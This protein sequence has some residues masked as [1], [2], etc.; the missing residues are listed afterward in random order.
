MTLNKLLNINIMGEQNKYGERYDISDHEAI[1]VE[2]IRLYTP[3][4]LIKIYQFMNSTNKKVF[5][6]GDD[7]Q[8]KPFG[9]FLNNVKNV[10]EYLDR[11][12]NI[13]FP[14][15]IML[16]F[17]KRA[18]TKEDQMLLHKIKAD[19]FDYTKEISTT[20]QLLQ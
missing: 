4:E 9:F 19:I 10:K 18:K 3:H 2:E 14:T 20:L 1:C 7:S 17:N 13:M 6:N 16:Q 12:I 8:N 11:I 5:A 15:Q